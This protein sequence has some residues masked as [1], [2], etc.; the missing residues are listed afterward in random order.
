MITTMTA[1][2]CENKGKNCHLARCP[3]FNISALVTILIVKIYEIK[4]SVMLALLGGY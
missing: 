4:V 2:S 3:Q 1:P